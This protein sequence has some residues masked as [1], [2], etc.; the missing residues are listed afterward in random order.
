VL[1][2]RFAAFKQEVIQR[3]D[4]AVVGFRIPPAQ[5]QEVH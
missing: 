2:E 1:D 4:L 5:Q 3:D